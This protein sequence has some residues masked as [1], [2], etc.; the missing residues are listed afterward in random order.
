[1]NIWKDYSY[2]EQLA[3]RTNMNYC[4]RFIANG[5]VII[6][7]SPTFFICFVEILR[8]EEKNLILSSKTLEFNLLYYIYINPHGKTYHIVKRTWC[9]SGRSPVLT[10][11]YKTFL[12]EISVL[13]VDV[14]SVH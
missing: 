7:C 12:T 8:T 2:Y 13:L 3:K 14:R 5:L 10:Y 1:M 6:R 4:C 11:D 9:V